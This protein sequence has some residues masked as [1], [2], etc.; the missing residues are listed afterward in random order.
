MTYCAGWKHKGSVHLLA[1]TVAASSMSPS[2][3]QIS[4]GELLTERH[5]EPVEESSL[6]LLP[7]ASGTVLACAGDVE[8]GALIVDFL[9][10]NQRHAAHHNELL[11]LLERAL[12]PFDDEKS[13]ALLLASSSSDGSAELLRWT[14]AQGLDTSASDFLQIGS[15]TAYHAAL[16]PQLLSALAASDLSSDRLLPVLT[17]I[18]QSH[19]ARDTSIDLAAAGLVFGLRTEGGSVTWQPDT[20]VVCYDQSFASSAHVA[21]LARDDELVV[22]SSQDNAIR[23]F[24]SSTPLRHRTP[25]NA[26]WL[27][28]IQ[29]ELAADRFRYRVFIS[30]SEQVITL[31]IRND[32]ERES[33]YLRL[34]ARRNGQFDLA[35]SPELTSLL[36]RPLH[37]RSPGAIP[38]QLSIRDD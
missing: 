5:G 22:H 27:R 14:T 1:D 7:M 21:V 20:L 26:A 12:G 33:R 30:T 2:R 28:D 29:A 8:L 32:F 17:A 11:T 9:Q 16:S 36:L 4:L 19:G 3:Q 25:R 31:I 34:K 13:V 18:V 24:A 35:L 15:P 6:K 10:A 37:D 23:V 38:L